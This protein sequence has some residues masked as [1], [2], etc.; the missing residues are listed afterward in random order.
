MIMSYP[1]SQSYIGSG[2]EELMLIVA[3]QYSRVMFQLIRYNQR[4]GEI[5]RLLASVKSPG[6]LQLNNPVF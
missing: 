1:I 4:K 3:V 5:I 2:D 6:S